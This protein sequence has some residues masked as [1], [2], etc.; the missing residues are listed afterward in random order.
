MGK[1]FMRNVVLSKKLIFDILFVLLCVSL[2][3]RLYVHLFSALGYDS[4]SVSEYLI[5]YQGGFVRRGIVGEILFFFA[6][7]FDFDIEWTIK[8]I[9]LFFFIFVSSF[10]I[11]SFLK[12]GYSLYLLPLC[13]FLGGM[14]S[15]SHWYLAFWIRKDFL[16]MAFFIVILWIWNC[17]RK[18]SPLFL[19][20][21]LIN[22][23]SIFT[24]LTHEVVVFFS[25][26]ILFLLFL[27]LYKNKKTSIAIILSFLS[28]SPSILAFFTVFFMHGDQQTAQAI[29]DSWSFLLLGVVSDIPP[30]AIDAI[31]WTNEHAINR[32]LMENFLKVEKD[33]LS[34]VYWCIVFPVVYY[35]STNALLVFRKKEEDFTVDHKTKL[36]SIL[37]FQ[38]ICLFPVLCI[39]SCD[40]VRI[41]FYWIASSFAIFLIVPMTTLEKLFPEKFIKLVEAINKRLSNLLTPT[42]THIAFFMLFIGISCVSF[43]FLYIYESSAVYQILYIISKPFVFAIN[44]I[45]SPL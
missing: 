40:W 18:N 35:I 10:F 14:I 37:L 43:D 26:P 12:K 24:I 44:H 34:S 4:W 7:N 25:L 36:S 23:L 30:K 20:V 6:N 22:L 2:L 1:S 32:H 33:I 15:S 11:K 42:K 19:K 41:I 8:V 39:L 5:N 45:L 3:Y 31:G 27:H 13:F 29:W 28:L 9:C 21:V 38:F 16:M 17:N